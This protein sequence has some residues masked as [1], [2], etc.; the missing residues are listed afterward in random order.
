M[1]IPNKELDYSL[2]EYVERFNKIKRMHESKNSLSCF[3]FCSLVFYTIA[4]II[5]G[6][7]EIKFS[8]VQIDFE[9]ELLEIVKGLF[10]IL[11]C[12][13]LDKYGDFI[14]LPKYAAIT[15]CKIE[16]EDRLKDIDYICNNMEQ[17]IKE[18][19]EII[20]EKQIDWLL[21]PE[22]VGILNDLILGNI[23]LNVN[24]YPIFQII[25]SKMPTSS[26]VKML[27]ENLGIS[28]NHSI[29]KNVKKL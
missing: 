9:V 5:D 27:K 4:C 20:G 12:Y 21:S 18:S 26:S 8:L 19:F 29:V 17:A 28:D 25:F 7:F 2:H 6:F 3:V 10:F 13:Q 23:E 16:T 11:V 15:E 24:H 1:C 22:S 14:R